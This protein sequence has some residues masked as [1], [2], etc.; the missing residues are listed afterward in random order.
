[1]ANEVYVSNH[2]SLVDSEIFIP[3]LEELLA[4]RPF[5]KDLCVFKGDVK[6]SGGT[7]LSQPQIKLNDV[8][9]SVAEGSAVS[10]NTA[11]TDGAYTLAPGRLAIKRVL[12]DLMNIISANGMLNP[13]QLALWNHRAIMLGFDGLVTAALAN[14]TGTVGT[15]GSPLTLLQFQSAY[16]TILT[17]DAAGQ[18]DRVISILHPKQ[19]NDLK[20][21]LLNYN[22]VALDRQDV[23][24]LAQMRGTSYQGTLD[25]VEIWV[26]TQVID[27][28]S[29]AD[30]NGAMF[31]HGG[32]GYGQGGAKDGEYGRMLHDD[33]VVYTTFKN[34]SDKAETEIV[35]NGF[36]AVSVTE[37]AKG[38]KIITDH[39]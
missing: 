26:S 20:K 10:A 36:Y 19:L 23:K 17:R 21:D 2:A 38:I 37:A 4:K 34:N 12:S 18:M 22:A 8:A 6:D 1:M 30:H 7:T 24:D 33:T 5:M 31:I 32:L 35:T 15:S 9:E 39:I 11:L 27:A 14:F 3:E 29:T 25:G 13:Q 28:N 16:Q